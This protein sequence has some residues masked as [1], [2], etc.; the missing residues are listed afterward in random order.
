MALTEVYTLTF[1]YQGEVVTYT[2]YN[3]SALISLVTSLGITNYDLTSIIED[4]IIEPSTDITDYTSGIENTPNT[5]DNTFLTKQD[6]YV[7]NNYVET[8]VPENI[9]ATAQVAESLTIINQTLVISAT[10]ASFD[11]PIEFQD[12][13]IMQSGGLAVP[14]PEQNPYIVFGTENQKIG[15][16]PIISLPDATTSDVLY[17]DWNLQEPNYYGMKYNGTFELDYT[18]FRN[19][20][21]GDT[22]QTGRITVHAASW[23]ENPLVP[24][25]THDVY[26]YINETDDPFLNNGINFEVAEGG[27]YISL[28]GTNN[29]GSSGIIKGLYKMY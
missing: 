4:I 26:Y 27:T 5:G 19:V 24:T 14:D 18:I 9:E 10:S 15:H 29:F 1:T 17:I 22:I 25:L 16:I 23:T 20:T 28:R 11:V 21:L 7:T 2:D 12:K 3:Y 8:A 6:Q 13:I